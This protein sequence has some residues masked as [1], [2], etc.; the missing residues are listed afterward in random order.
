MPRSTMLP[1]SGT[2]LSGGITLFLSSQVA[3]NLES[4]VLI[5]MT[6]QE[7]SAALLRHELQEC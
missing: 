4:L 5:A 6:L 3:A 2:L 7:A 1:G